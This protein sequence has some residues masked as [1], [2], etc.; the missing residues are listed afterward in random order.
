MGQ[1]GNIGRNTFIG[2]G[3]NNT[4]A[5]LRKDFRVM[6]KRELQFRSEFYNLFNQ[7]NLTGIRDDTGDSLFGHATSTYSM[8]NVQ[9]GLK[10]VF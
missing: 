8:R 1:N 5:T 9:F 3:Y 4:N 2:P 10:F 6:E 7:T